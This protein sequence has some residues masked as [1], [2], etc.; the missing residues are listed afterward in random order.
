[1]AQVNFFSQGIKFDV[2]NPRKL[3]KW[4]KNTA[5]KE[6]SKLKEVNYIFCSDKKLLAIN[7]QYLRHTTLTDIITF[8]NSEEPGQLESD[9]FISVQRVKENA[10][11][12]KLPFE[13][14]LRRVMIHGVLHLLGYGDKSSSEKAIMRK[15]EEA[16]LS[17]Y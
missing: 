12:L 7:K 8:D 13:V 17:L 2:K 16:Y 3:S 5:N 9:I 6:G 1:M 10:L 11:K 4:I 15:K 14:E